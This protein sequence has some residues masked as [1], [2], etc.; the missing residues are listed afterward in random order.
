LHST[1]RVA[2]VSACPH[3]VAHAA[4][5]GARQLYAMAGHAAVAEQVLLANGIDS[6]QL[7]ALA[8]T[9]PSLPVHVTARVAVEPGCPHSAGHGAKGVAAQKKSPENSGGS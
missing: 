2:V 5:A 9:A 7:A 6:V 3:A 8:A 1:A 4:K